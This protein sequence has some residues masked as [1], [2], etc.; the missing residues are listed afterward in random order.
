MTRIYKVSKGEYPAPPCAGRDSNLKEAL[1]PIHATDSRSRLLSEFGLTIR[2]FRMD[3][4]GERV[5]RLQPEIRIVLQHVSDFSGDR[6][7]V[8]LVFAPRTHRLDRSDSPRSRPGRSRRY[9]R[10]IKLR[11]CFFID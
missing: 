5:R 7:A 8:Y 4:L 6:V 2:V 11:R 3:T 10:Q 1:R 9:L